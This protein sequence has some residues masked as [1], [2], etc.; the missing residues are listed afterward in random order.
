MKF[1]NSLKAALLAFSLVTST[2]VPAIAA[3]TNVVAE[4]G[5]VSAAK[6]LSPADGYHAAWKFVRDNYVDQTFNG[7]DWSTWEHKFAPQTEAEEVSAIKAM[8]E[9]L[10]DP[11]TRVRQLV[12]AAES[13]AQIASV[14]EISGENAVSHKMLSDNI[15]Y[16]KIGSFASAECAREFKA[17]LK[18]LASAESIVI[19]LRGN[20]GGLVVNALKIA[21][22]FLTTERIVTTVSRDGRETFS[23]SAS[24]LSKQ[25]LVVLVDNQTASASE[26]LT[27]ALKDNHRATVIG[28][29]TYGK[30]LIQDV[31]YIHGLMLTCTTARYLT[32]EGNDINAKGL[33]PDITSGDETQL[34]QTAVNFLKRRIASAF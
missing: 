26:I 7:Q 1:S 25:E 33:E 11:Y 10:N 20:K 22:M 30:G 27:A 24:P 12:D 31:Q 23:A 4:T 17:S 14:V 21:D 6:T 2:L 15:G 19:D 5:S 32:P 28:G 8:M 16:I 3:S 13:P 29:K 18:Q 9:S 34:M